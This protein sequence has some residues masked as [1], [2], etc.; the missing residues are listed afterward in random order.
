MYQEESYRVREQAGLSDK[1]RRND[2]PYKIKLVRLCKSE[3]SYNT[4]EMG[5][6]NWYHD[7]YSFHIACRIPVDT[8]GGDSEASYVRRHFKD[9]V[10]GTH[11]E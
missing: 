10:V 2:H 11:V 9:S 5:V 4:C 6:F 3:R 8:S 7:R 1:R